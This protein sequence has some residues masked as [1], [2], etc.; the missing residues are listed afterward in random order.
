LFTITIEITFTARHQL[1]ATDGGKEPLH[2]HDCGV[3]AAVSAER[4]DE[5]GLVCDFNDLKA[6]LKEITAPFNGPQLEELA[7]FQDI[8]ASAENVAKYIYD[9]LE[10]LLPCHTKLQY[11]EVTEAPGC[12]AKYFR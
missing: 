12:R 11:I 3:R 10:P 9:K 4:L 7:C 6:K 5:M 8:N 1:T 2:S